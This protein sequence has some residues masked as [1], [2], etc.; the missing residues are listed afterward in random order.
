MSISAGWLRMT[1]R[2]RAISAV[3]YVLI[4]M[5]FGILMMYLFQNAHRKV[6]RFLALTFLKL[7][8]VKVQVQGELDPRAQ[9]LIMNGCDLF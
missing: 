6:R 8:R 7:F 1:S 4:V 9:I 2:I 5:P 3:L